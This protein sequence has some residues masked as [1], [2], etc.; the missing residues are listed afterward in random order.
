MLRVPYI[1]VLLLY[2]VV[3]T[4]HLLPAVLPKALTERV[5]WIAAFAVGLHVLALSTEAYL[6]SWTPGL[7]EA[8]S[9]VGLGVMCAYVGV[10]HG[11]QRALGLLLGPLA[12]VAVGTALVVPHREVVG[13][14]ATGTAVAWL[15]IHLGLLFAGIGGFALSAVVGAMY[16]FVQRSLKAKR[17][18]RI[19]RLPSL[20]TLDRTQFR[21]MLFG[22]IALTLGIGAGGMLAAA[23]FQENWV[24]D[25]K[26][27]YTI[28]IWFW[29][30][31]ALQVRVVWGRRGNWTARFSILGFAGMIFSLVGINFLLNGFHAYG[32]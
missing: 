18:D 16:L 4:V 12:L 10:A 15:P 31:V 20:E 13:L 30:G 2:A 3:S 24:L 8:L 32:A 19:R 26:V 14:Q 5:R 27:V 23:S 25:P 6:G 28:A 29:Y 17:F 1:P 7:P 11:K 9:A 22:F 21:S